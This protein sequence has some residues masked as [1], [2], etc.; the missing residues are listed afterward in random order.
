MEVGA[1]DNANSTTASKSQQNGQGGDET[2]EA[3]QNTEPSNQDAILQQ[4][5]SDKDLPGI[6]EGVGTTASAIPLPQ[7]KTKAKRPK[8]K[9]SPSKAKGKS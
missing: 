6:S 9:A 2:E 4:E 8:F 7:A 1:S 3:D 5:T